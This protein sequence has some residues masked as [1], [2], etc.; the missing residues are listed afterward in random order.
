MLRS[1]NLRSNF[2][3]KDRALVLSSESNIPISALKH[4]PHP[5]HQIR[6]A[7]TVL[8]QFGF[9]WTEAILLSLAGN[10]KSF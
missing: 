5:V 4:M 1:I 2:S 7:Q 3:L 8:F 6:S 10:V 9:D